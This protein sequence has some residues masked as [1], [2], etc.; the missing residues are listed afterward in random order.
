[1]PNWVD[2]TLDVLG[3]KA[4]VDEFIKFMNTSYTTKHFDY[5]RNEDG[6][7]T[8]EIK[9]STHSNIFNFHAIVPIPSDP[10]LYDDQVFEDGS[11]SQPWYD[12]NI[13]N[14]GTKWNA[15]DAHL[16][17]RGEDTVAYYF[18]TAWSPPMPVIDKL[19][20]LFPTMTFF[21]RYTEEQ[22]WGGEVTIRSGEVTHTEEWDIPSTHAEYELR[23][24]ECSCSWETDQ[25]YWF[26]DC[27]REEETAN[28]V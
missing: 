11:T 15:I 26:S 17:R 8:K 14:W 1:M 25:E 27:P 23:Q 10:K 24:G 6:T 4:E 9:E 28:A 7:M 21:Y 12:W 20:K 3:T 5:K 19:R 22:G 16:D 13:S 2:N 18:N